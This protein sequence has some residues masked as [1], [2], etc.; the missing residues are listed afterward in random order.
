[1][2]DKL[3]KPLQKSKFRKY[4]TPTVIHV[5]YQHIKVT[6]E[7]LLDQAQGCYIADKSEIR[8]LEGIEG[9]ELLNTILHEC[10]HAIAYTYGLKKDFKDD[11]EEEK[12]VN[13]FGNGLTEIL[14]RNP[15]LIK[16]I[17]GIL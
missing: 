17:N 12:I 1:M 3:K 8:I 9:R 16:M 2:E 13:V 4:I 7:D 5:G 15:D 11:E 6:E 14:I 10:L